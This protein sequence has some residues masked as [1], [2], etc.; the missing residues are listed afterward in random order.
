MRTLPRRYW[1]RNPRVAPLTREC[2]FDAGKRGQ[3]TQA[4]SCGRYLGL[5]P[6]PCMRGIR[7]TSKSCAIL[8]AAM[9]GG[10]EIVSWGLFQLPSGAAFMPL[11]NHW[12]T[13]RTH[14][15][16]E[17]AHRL[18]MDYDRR[19]SEISESWIWFDFVHTFSLLNRIMR[20][21]SRDGVGRCRVIGSFAGVMASWTHS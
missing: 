14:A 6:R 11:P 15:R 20:E 16:N 3:R 10:D 1:M 12:V 21:G 9:S 5:A 13:E 2:D 17:Q 19:K 8:P 4:R 18:I 7:S